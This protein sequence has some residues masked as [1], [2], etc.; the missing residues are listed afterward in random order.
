MSF[1]LVLRPDTMPMYS[2][3]GIISVSYPVCYR[4][5][6]GFQLYYQAAYSVHPTS[7]VIAPHDVKFSYGITPT[8]TRLNN[9]DTTKLILNI[10]HP[11]K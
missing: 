7:P 6:L 8:P 11:K 2:L 1:V 5:P 4:C 10:L 9:P 3:S